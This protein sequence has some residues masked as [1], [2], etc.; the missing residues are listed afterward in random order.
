MHALQE[1][2][3][4]QS[5]LKGQVKAQLANRGVSK[6]NTQLP[7]CQNTCSPAVIQFQLLK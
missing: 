1:K 4:K 3:S 2:H 6:S 7:K 5:A